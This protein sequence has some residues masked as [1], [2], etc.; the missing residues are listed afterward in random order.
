MIDSLNK[1]YRVSLSEIDN[2]KNADYILVRKNNL[3]IMVSLQSLKKYSKKIERLCGDLTKNVLYY[4]VNN[5]I[6]ADVI[7]AGRA[8]IRLMNIDKNT[9][10]TIGRNLKNES[11]IFDA[12]I[13][14]TYP[15]IPAP[16]VYNI[17]TTGEIEE[18]LI[19]N[20]NRKKHLLS[21]P[22]DVLE[23]LRLLIP[24]V[25]KY[26]IIKDSKHYSI[27]NGQL[28]K[29]DHILKDETSNIYLVDWSEGGDKDENGRYHIFFDIISSIKWVIF[30]RRFTTY[31]H[32]RYIDEFINIAYD[33]SKYIGMKAWKKEF[34]ETMELCY[35]NR[36]R[37]NKSN[38]LVKN[39][40]KRVEDR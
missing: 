28:Y 13:R 39:L 19:I 21:T 3:E 24:S 31:Y 27:V 22:M 30:G 18:E 11:A 37:F 7:I 26:Y 20:T 16:K 25:C 1:Y 40:I 35:N 14:Q 5:N 29:S 8:K 34:I 15:L 38:L 12:K 33:I 36:H 23:A 9:V 10:I 6:M 4:Q 2:R 17:N 32:L